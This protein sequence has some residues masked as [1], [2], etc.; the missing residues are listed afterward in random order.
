[1]S[2]TK[3]RMAAQRKPWFPR[4]FWLIKPFDRIKESKKLYNRNREKVETR[5]MI[6]EC[7]KHLLIILLLVVTLT[8]PKT[9]YAG[10][11]EWATAGKVITGIIVYECIF[12][13]IVRGLFAPEPEY[14]VVYSYDHQYSPQRDV[15][16]YRYYYPAQRKVYIYEYHYYGYGR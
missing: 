6:R 5:K 7:L 11:K 12:R 3:T 1:M 16:V 15:Y 8:M 2:G 14:V 4:R 9:T 13:P 10:Q